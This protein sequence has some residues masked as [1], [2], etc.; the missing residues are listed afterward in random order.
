MRLART[1]RIPALLWTGLMLLAISCDLG[2]QPVTPGQGGSIIG[3]GLDSTNGNMSIYAS[4]TSVLASKTDV[5]NIFVVIYDENHNPVAG[6]LV[7][8]HAN[9]GVVQEYA[10][11]DSTGKASVAFTA[12][13]INTDALVWASMETEDSTVTVGTYVHMSGMELSIATDFSDALLNADVPV[14]VRL[15]DG[16]GQLVSNALVRLTGTTDTMGTTTSGQFS[17]TVSKSSQGTY[18]ISASALGASDTDT[19]RFWTTIPT[20]TQTS[21][22]SIRALRLYSS[23][24]QLNADNTDN[25]SITAIVTN[26]KNNPLAG[27]TVRFSTNL[28]VID[29]YAIADAAGR[30]VATLRSTPVN[31]VCMVI[32]EVAGQT[33]LRDTVSVIFAGIGLTL[34]ATPSDLSVNDTS[35]IEVVVQDAS[36]N[37]IGGDMVTFSITTSI[38]AFLDGSKTKSAQLDANGKGS[39]QVTSSI[40]GRVIVQASGLNRSVTKDIQF[41]TSNLTLVASKSSM[42]AGGLDSIRVTATYRDNSGAVVPNK[43]I[44]FAAN[45]GIVTDDSVT[46]GSNGTASTWLRSP[47]FSGVAKVEVR[48]ADQSAGIASVTIGVLAGP[49]AS[50]DLAVT[51]DNIR[52]RGGVATLMATIKD[53]N[54]NMVSGVNVNFVLLQSP[55]GGDSIRY[56]VSQASNGVAQSELVAGD[57]PSFYRSVE[58]A[59]YVGPIADSSKLTISGDPFIVTVSRPQDD[60]VTVPMAGNLNPSTFSHNVGAVIQDINGNPV[61]DGTPVHFSAVVSGMAVYRK[62]LLKWAGL[63]SDA[64]D[65]AELGYR[66]LDVP[67]EDVNNNFGMDDNIDL[68]LDVYNTIARRGDDFDGLG[69]V[70]Y[71]PLSDDFFWDFNNNGVCDTVHPVVNLG[72]QYDTTKIEINADRDALPIRTYTDTIYVPNARSWLFPS[73]MVIR[74]ITQDT[75]L[76]YS[77]D[78]TISVELQAFQEIY[79]VLNDE[80]P[81]SLV[82][83]TATGRI[84]RLPREAAIAYEGMNT[85]IGEPRIRG[86]NGSWIYADLNEN[87]RRDNTEWDDYNNNN[88]KDLPAI[89]YTSPAHDFRFWLWEMLPFW[90]GNPFEFHQNDFAVVIEKSVTTINGVADTKLTYPRQFARRLLVNVNAESQGIRDKDGER[91]LLKVVE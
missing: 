18:V 73:V 54:G 60:T 37:A 15:V 69:A 26:E 61:A 23:K 85:G 89:F 5:A 52:V 32:A 27:D 63:G 91:F 48:A 65:K 7:T 84:I 55:G 57:V 11:T 19:V 24:S 50:V 9:H 31:G 2:E 47:D 53:A 16:A 4:P 79:T 82:G 87:G 59:A 71:D 12:E 49:A 76:S 46:T 83:Q 22:Q 20:G 13:Q 72:T 67:F 70:D 51:P 41:S 40:A 21:V 75:A 88:V 56:P 3:P 14:A 64:E 10:T 33:D 80:N 42:V 68:K 29:G 78:D 74:H 36:K 6:R 34:N 28:G 35:L 86:D 90:K 1:I 66:Y 25:A 43:V 45:A 81:D 38:G 77:L 58:V 62:H 17:T 44:I 30:A 8:F 39:I